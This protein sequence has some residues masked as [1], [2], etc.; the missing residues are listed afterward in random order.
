MLKLVAAAAAA[1]A[2]LGCLVMGVGTGGTGKG[3]RAG[4][5]ALGG[6][7]GGGD[8]GVALNGVS[9]YSFVCRSF[10]GRGVAKETGGGG[11]SGGRGAVMG[12]G[13]LIIG[14]RGRCARGTV[15]GPPLLAMRPLTAEPGT[16]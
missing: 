8:G 16:T 1:A 10:S 13:T 15:V 2:E 5:V 7:G 3:S 12:T 9:T 4:R 11:R 14:A 6:W